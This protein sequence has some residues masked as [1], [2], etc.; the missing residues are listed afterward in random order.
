MPIIKSAFV[1][2]PIE[3]EQDFAHAQS[4]NVRFMENLMR[5]FDDDDEDD[6]SRSC[7]AAAA[8]LPGRA[9][10][11]RAI[12]IIKENSEILDKILRKKGER[13]NQVKTR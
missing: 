5:D 2:E 10:S 13:Y 9:N 12:R 6:V 8:A 4:S 1:P 7:E 11:E 3:E